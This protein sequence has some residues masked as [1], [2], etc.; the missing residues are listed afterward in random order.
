MTGTTSGLWVPYYCAHFTQPFEPQVMAG[1]ILPVVV[2]EFQFNGSFLKLGKNIG[3]PSGATFWGVGAG[4]WG[5]KFVL[6]TF[7]FKWFVD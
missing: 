3:F 4:I 6:E 7:L 5:R 1:L 2:N